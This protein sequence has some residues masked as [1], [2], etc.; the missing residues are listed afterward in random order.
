[1]LSISLSELSVFFL[2]Y[3][4]DVE[5]LRIEEHGFNKEI[6]DECMDLD[7][8]VAER[9]FVDENRQISFFNNRVRALYEMK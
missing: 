4:M 3:D 2:K 6:F 8:Q 9:W 1:M 7:K 5:Q